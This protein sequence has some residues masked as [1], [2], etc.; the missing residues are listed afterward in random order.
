MEVSMLNLTEVLFLSVMLGLLL[1][2]GGFLVQRLSP[3][4][5]RLSD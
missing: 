4:G 5:G 1:S 3:Y 2:L